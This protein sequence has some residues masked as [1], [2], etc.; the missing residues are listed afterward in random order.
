MDFGIGLTSGVDAWKTAQRAEELG[1]SHVWLVDTQMLCADVFVAMALAAEHTTRIRIGSGVII[2]S[3][4]IAPVTANGLA[5]VA[6]LAPGRV[7][8]GVGTGFTGRNTMGLPAMRLADLREHVRVIQALLRGETVEWEAEG[9]P[10]KIRFLNPDA[11]LIDIGPKIPLHL[12]AFGPRAR[13]LTVEVADGWM[14]F[15]GRL[16]SGLR[17]LAAIGEVCRAGGRTPASLYKTTFTMG[18]VLGDGEPADSPRARAQAGPFAMTV[19]HSLMDGS[20]PMRAPTAI[21]SA[22][23]EYRTLY[24]SYEPA[25]ARYLA[26]HRGHFMFLRPEEERFASA[27]ALRELTFTA[28]LPELRDRVRALRDAGADQFA[29]FLAPR[30][31]DAIEDWARVVEKV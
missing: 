29:V 11:G 2:P 25:D 20:L 26:L 28:T 6:K 23:P 30:H 4:R 18:C 15:A 7:D 8:F 31:E 9:R 14:H 21:A 3:N 13:A 10:R 22:V 19:F 24:E 1:F 16:S 17:D 27:A 5:S 12:S